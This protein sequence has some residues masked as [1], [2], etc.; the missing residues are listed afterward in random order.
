[1]GVDY[2]LFVKRCRGRAILRRGKTIHASIAREWKFDAE[3]HALLE[4][5]TTSAR[6]EIE[7]ENGDEWRPCKHC[8]AEKGR[9]H[10][11]CRMCKGDERIAC[12]TLTVKDLT[13]QEVEAEE[14]AFR[15]KR[16]DYEK[17]LE[18][19]GRA[20]LSGEWGRQGR[21]IRKSGGL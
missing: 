13:V 1:M 20:P 8:E 10:A 11:V 3:I 21:V 6:I 18:N 14:E 19:K 15:K 12:W 4:T 2:T 5:L 16:E 17:R 7:R 9:G